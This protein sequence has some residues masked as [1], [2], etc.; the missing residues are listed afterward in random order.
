MY[1]FT[2]TPSRPLSS[3]NKH[4]YNKYLDNMVVETEGTFEVDGHSLYTKSWLVRNNLT[5]PR[6]VTPRPHAT[7]D[8]KC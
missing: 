3:L 1:N 8:A 5:C 4:I 6:S 2:A 7:D